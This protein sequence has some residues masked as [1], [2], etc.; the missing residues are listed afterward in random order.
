M[1]KESTILAMYE[2]LREAG[3]VKLFETSSTQFFMG[4][5]ATLSAPISGEMFIEMIT[6]PTDGD[7]AMDDISKSFATSAVKPDDTLRYHVIVSNE[8]E[9]H[10]VILLESSLLGRVEGLENIETAISAIHLGS[11]GGEVKDFVKSVMLIGNGSS[12]VT[13]VTRGMLIKHELTHVLYTYITDI[14]EPNLIKNCGGN[15][16]TDEEMHEFVEFICDFTMYDASVINKFTV[17]PINKF[18]D[19]LDINFKK[20]TKEKYAKYIKPLSLYFD[21]LMAK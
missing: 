6:N 16:L 5:A 20:G 2:A 14:R 8:F 17:N 7:V 12:Q 11:R 1:I 9:I 15:E 10:Y 18:C 19:D 4:I 3:L 21:E 13:D